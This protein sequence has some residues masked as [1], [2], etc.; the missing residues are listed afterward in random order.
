M[1]KVL[2]LTLGLVVVFV[3]ASAGFAQVPTG[4]LEGTV[5]DP[6][7]AV[8]QGATVS[9]RN[10]A[11]NNLRVATTGDNG[12]YR[13]ADLAPGVYE[14][15][16]TAA[17]FKTTVASD[18]RVEVG[19]NVPMDVKLEIGAP[20]AEV[21]VV[22]GG[23]VQIDRTDNTVAGVV[24]TR[25]I[26][27]LPLN[28]RNFLDLAQLQPG[29]EKVDGASFDPTK[30]NYTG[31]SIA[32]QAGRSTQITVDGGSVVDNIVGTTTQNFS[33]E[34][35][36][37]FQMGISNF[38]LSTG[39]SATG[40]VNIVSRSGT[41]EFHGNAYGYFRDAKWAAFP[42]LFR[43]DA[44]NGL[45]PNARTNRIPF[46]RRQFGGTIGGPIKKDKA[47]FFFNFERNNQNGASVKNPTDLSSF[48]G[49]TTTPFR[50][51][52]LTAKTD[53]NL[54]NKNSMFVRYS[55]DDNHGQNPFP[56]GTGIV[57]R[58]GSTLF[59]T[60]D[61]VVKN[62]TQ[63][64]VFGLTTQLRAHVTNDARYNYN[65]FDDIIDPATAPA[66]ALGELRV[67]NGGDQSWRSGT[68]YIA[69]QTTFQRRNQIRDD[70]TWTHSA[71]TIRFGGDFEHT[72]IFGRFAFAKPSRV[73]IFG[74]DDPGGPPALLTE[75]QFLAAPVRDF[76]L[77]IG[78]DTLPF[79]DTKGRTVNNRIQ[80]YATDSWKLTK[81]FTANLGLAYRYD[82]NLYNLD[83]TRP[84]II[85]PLFDKGTSRV[86]NDKNNW[87][88]RLGF[89]WDLKGNG[90]TVVR[91]GVGMYYDTTID[92]LRL[93]E[94]ADLGKPGSE[95]FLTGT[96]IRSALL[97]G[98]D[99]RF[100]TSPTSSSGFITLGNLLP[101]LPA[102]RTELE[103]RLKSCTLPTGLQ[104][105][106]AIS[107]PLFQQNFQ[108]PYSIQWSIGVQ[109]ELP[110]KMVLQ[111][112]YNF[113]KGVHE[114][115]TYDA[116]FAE[117]A[118]GPK[119]A[120]WSNSVPVAQSGG[121]STYSGL[122]T[123]LDRRFNKGFQFTASYT[124][125]RFKAFG[126]D[127][128]GLGATTTDLNNFR[129]EFGPTGLD[130]TH[131]L[132][133]SGLW[134]LPWFT[135]S[136]SWAKRNL[137]G[138][139]NISVISTAFSGVPRNAFIPDGVNLS[140]TT[141]LIGS[142]L[143]GTGPGAVGRQIKSVTQFNTLITAY[144]TSIPH[145]GIACPGGSSTGRCDP[146]GD[147]LEPIPLLPANT[148]IGGDSLI[149]QD[150]RLTKRFHFSERT[151]L[152]LMGEVFNLFNIA[153]LTG[154]STEDV[155]PGNLTPTNRQTSIFGTGGP[156][157][158]QFAAKFRF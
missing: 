31:V 121:F 96:A 106:G 81:R 60:D 24:N 77:G 142:Y 71:Q 6:Q 147:P 146:F 90:R 9:A 64:V 32:G 42:G 11:T 26:E 53:I 138:N 17:N 20:S 36:Q 67:W 113:R 78:N 127:T 68:N 34:I 58:S 49:F 72:S 124:L 35:V 150:L 126:S 66:G 48:A 117:S 125:S 22:G 141:F 154:F 99:A 8:V 3:L 2:M 137:L 13:I 82:T 12:H 65:H 83:L 151:S 94:R 129:T 33:Q 152:D 70:V 91:G 89:A 85:A 50:E 18:V 157:A 84:A 135:K 19:A 145:L 104:C 73:R 116:N 153:N 111:S 45:P 158:F 120:T 23:E 105:A 140:G 139:W 59:Q 55:F 41:N 118:T 130:R 61:Q 112:D 109:R 57:P 29:T 87:A 134:D 156:R 43:L 92:N 103:N 7:G 107:G 5:S 101:L 100:S 110:W 46:N 30:A 88:P 39:A 148:Q 144:N 28:G 80:F 40:S 128:L 21:T 52:L 74:P 15:K 102:V 62:R 108:L 51:S 98:G 25:Q 79:A 44:A 37:E 86:P 47:F 27:T 123:R 122:L 56:E 4:A 115:F 114:V 38:D 155:G 97:P 93:F 149:S 63:G 69:P 95:L 16:V 131:R 119:L 133:V 76:S 10:K 1:R 14:V 132:V 143:P 75:A 54:N 136:S